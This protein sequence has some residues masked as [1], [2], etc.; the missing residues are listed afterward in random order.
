MF[1]APS[2]EYTYAISDDD[3]CCEVFGALVDLSVFSVM[4]LEILITLDYQSSE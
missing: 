2:I 3:S 4:W 1:D